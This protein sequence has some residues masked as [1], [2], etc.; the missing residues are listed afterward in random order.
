MFSACQSRSL[1]LLCQ[2]PNKKPTM[3]LTCA[4]WNRTT[5][6]LSPY[7]FEACTHH[8]AGSCTPFRL[9]SACNNVGI[10]HIMIGHTHSTCFAA[11]KKL[12]YSTKCTV[13]NNG[14]DLCTSFHRIRIKVSL[15]SRPPSLSRPGRRASPCAWRCSLRYRGSSCPCSS[16]P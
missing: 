8:Q 2:R 3:D 7:R 11:T 16:P 13:F 5:G 6:P 10:V 14:V 1:S 12:L 9:N 4:R 15:Y